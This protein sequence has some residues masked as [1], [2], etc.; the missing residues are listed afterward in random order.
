M[1]RAI[2]NNVVVAES[3]RCEEVEGN[4]YFPAS[5][6]NERYFEPSA[7]SSVCGWKGTAGYFDLVVD[8]KRNEAA[9]WVYRDPKPAAANIRD[10]VAFWNGVTVER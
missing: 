5:A 1:P 2:W 7:R 3:E 10:M 9:A 4:L 8:G 6:L